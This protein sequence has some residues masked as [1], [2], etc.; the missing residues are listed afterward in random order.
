MRRPKAIAWLGMVLAAITIGLTVSTPLAHAQS[1]DATENVKIGVVMLYRN[2][3]FTDIAA[4][5]TYVFCGGVPRQ[6]NGVVSSYGNQ[7]QPGCQAKLRN[8]AGEEFALC[9]GRGTIPARFRL[10]PRLYLQFG[11]S[12]VCTQ[13]KDVAELRAGLLS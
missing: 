1:N 12:P 8:S 11:L 6:I 2:P 3:D 5:I 4:R 13:R 7:P 10:S 9:A